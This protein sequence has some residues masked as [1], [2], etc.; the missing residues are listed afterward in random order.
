MQVRLTPAEVMTAYQV[1]AMRRLQNAIRGTPPKHGA[2]RGPHGEVIDLIAC[3]GE[4]AVA[5][6]LNL[7]WS[8][9][10]GDYGAPDVGGFLDVR[11]CQGKGHSLILHKEDP[12]RPFVLAWHESETCVHL[13]GWT[14]ARDVQREEFWRDPTGEGRW[15]YFVP[16][17]ELR[18][19]GE[20]EPII[21]GIWMIQR[22][23]AK[24]PSLEA[25]IAERL[26]RRDPDPV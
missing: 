22:K 14:M 6:A 4:M 9:T 18:R 1:T 24:Q 11:T 5:K 13:I 10:V 15:A 23:W 26:R 16:Q 7:Y 21:P 3:R 17:S 20:L 19:V 8:G 12:N 2:P 25:R